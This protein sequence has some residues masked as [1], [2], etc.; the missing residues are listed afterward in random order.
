MRKSKLQGMHATIALASGSPIGRAARDIHE[1]I[2]LPNAPNPL[3]VQRERRAR[4]AADALMLG[5]AIGAAVA[6]VWAVWSALS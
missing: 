1:E 3:R 2:T 5:L 4:A 6:F